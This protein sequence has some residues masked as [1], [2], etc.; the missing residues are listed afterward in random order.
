MGILIDASILIE[1][2]RK[3]LTLDSYLQ[4]RED[5]EFFLSVVTASELLHGV[6]RAQGAGVRA[7]RSAWVEAVL[8]RFPLLP[9]DLSVARAHAQ[10]WA[11]LAGEGRVIGAHDLWLAASCLAHGFAL[12]TANVREFERVP[13]LVLEHWHTDA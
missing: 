1:H 9:V 7:R 6:H 2:E 5:E 10:V 11:Q 4:G 12:V 8:E 3:Q 13:G